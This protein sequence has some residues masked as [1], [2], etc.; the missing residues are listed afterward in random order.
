M[1]QNRLTLHDL[2]SEPVMT[3]QLCPNAYESDSG[4][5][6]IAFRRALNRA[7]IYA[8]NSIRVK[9]LVNNVN[10]TM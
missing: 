2:R 4:F 10:L 8:Y 5:H 1:D 6:L 3:R 7:M 9:Y